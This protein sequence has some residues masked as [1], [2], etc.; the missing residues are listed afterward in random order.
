MAG[1]FP[2][3]IPAVFKWARLPGLPRSTTLSDNRV[4][5]IKFNMR[6]WQS[7][8]RL[9]FLNGVC[10]G[11]TPKKSYVKLGGRLLEKKRNLLSM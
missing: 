1:L 7:T 10:A 2:L 6:Q 5:N 8:R 4:T 9:A 3:Q 11:K